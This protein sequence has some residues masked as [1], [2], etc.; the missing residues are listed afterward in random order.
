M[1]IRSGLIKVVLLK[2]LPRGDRFREIGTRMTVFADVARKL[3]ADGSARYES[4]DETG[5]FFNSEE[6]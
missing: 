6:E 2:R 4:E 3:V 5:S 1:E